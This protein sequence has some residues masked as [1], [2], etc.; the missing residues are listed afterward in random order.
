MFN[1]I[2]VNK[3]SISLAVT[4]KRQPEAELSFTLQGQKH[5]LSMIPSGDNLTVSITMAT[6]TMMLQA[7]NAL[8][9][10]YIS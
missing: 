8:H 3:Y 7:K 5:K 4:K 6:N 9:L 1:D 10:Q 2:A